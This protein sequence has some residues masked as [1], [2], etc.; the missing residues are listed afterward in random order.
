MLWYWINYRFEGRDSNLRRNSLITLLKGDTGTSVY[1]YFPNSSFELTRSCW[2]V[3]SSKDFETLHQEIA[4][5]IHPDFDCVVLTQV[6]N[7]NIRIIGSY[8]D[9]VEEHDPTGK[10]VTLEQIFQ[11]HNVKID[12][13]DP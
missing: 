2:L 7:S 9:F 10:T 1:F 13:L 8:T 11:K 12:L 5:S 4:Q 6:T 3:N